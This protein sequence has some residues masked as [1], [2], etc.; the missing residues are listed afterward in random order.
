VTATL[1]G[2]ID[3]VSAR[4]GERVRAGQV[5]ARFADR[6]ER[7][8][9]ERLQAEYDERLVEFLRS[10]SNPSLRQRLAALE[11]EREA[12]HDRLQQLAVLAPCDG[13]IADLRVHSGQ[14][15]APGDALISI[16]GDESSVEIVG[17]FPGYTRPMLVAADTTVLLELDGFRDSRQRVQ[18]ATVA[19]EV[20]GPGEALRLLGRE[21][22]GTLAVEGPVVVVSVVLA[23]D[24][25]TVDGQR[26]RLYDGMLGRLDVK[27]R[28]ATII[29]HLVPGL[30]GAWGRE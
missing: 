18:I 3:T 8:E 22:E 16:E 5:L 2:T 14:Q 29:E 15:V 17:L 6:P 7:R 13:L 12:A 9:F 30:R 10:P 28:S 24:T 19:D 4:P 21:R 20:I 25:I 23:D 26:Y 11:Q 27:L 1:A